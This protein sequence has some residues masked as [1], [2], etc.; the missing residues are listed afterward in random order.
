MMAGVGVSDDNNDAQDGGAPVVA[1]ANASAQPQPSEQP[2]QTLVAGGGRAGNKHTPANHPRLVTREEFEQLSEERQVGL[3]V[4]MDDP[5][6]LDCAPLTL[7]SGAEAAIVRVLQF[8]TWYRFGVLLLT[9][10][11]IALGIY[12]TWLALRIDS[13][14]ADCET[15]VP[16]G[17]DPATFNTPCAEGSL[18]CNREQCCDCSS[19]AA[20]HNCSA[21]VGGAD[22]GAAPIEFVC[23]DIVC[24]GGGI[25][26]GG[27]GG[28]ITTCYTTHI[29]GGVPTAITAIDGVNLGLLGLLLLDLALCLHFLS[30]SL[31]YCRGSHRCV[32]LVCALCVLYVVFA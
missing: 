25:G 15:P 10:A 26:G 22:G 28:S 12:T 29:N 16:F 32:G 4:N 18:F 8:N 6:V 14:A 13:Q 7:R 24:G 17:E 30:K 31:C 3:L 27:G 11:S 20:T 5:H 9:V 21:G 19:Y 2:R 1:A 23:A